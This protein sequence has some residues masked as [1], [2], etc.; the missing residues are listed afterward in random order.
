MVRGHGTRTVVKARRDEIL[1][2]I[3]WG[4]TSRRSLEGRYGPIAFYDVDALWKQK[5]I[6]GLSRPVLSSTGRLY[7][8]DL[9]KAEINQAKGPL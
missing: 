9:R 8:E 7:L 2:D 3:A 6:V 5:L 4:G 1:K